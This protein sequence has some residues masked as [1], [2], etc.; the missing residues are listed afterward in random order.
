MMQCLRCNYPIGGVIEPRCPECGL[1]FDRTQRSTYRLEGDERTLELFDRKSVIW[2]LLIVPWLVAFAPYVSWK[3][4]DLFQGTPGPR[5]HPGLPGGVLWLPWVICVHCGALF[6][7]PLFALLSA[8]RL[9]RP[10][11]WVR[12]RDRRLWFWVGVLG[13]VALGA[14]HALVYLKNPRIMEWWRD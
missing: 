14:M 12:L 7:A 8:Y 3:S 13:Y 1:V 9:K 11:P 2:T 6:W 10:E 5:N 4:V